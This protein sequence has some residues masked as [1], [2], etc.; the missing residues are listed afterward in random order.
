MHKYPPPEPFLNSE[1]QFCILG[2]INCLKYIWL[3]FPRLFMIILW[4]F[5]QFLCTKCFQFYHIWIGSLVYHILNVFLLH[6]DHVLGLIGSWVS[7]KQSLTF[8]LAIL[9]HSYL[10][11]ALHFETIHCIILKGIWWPIFSWYQHISLKSWWY[12]CFLHQ[13]FDYNQLSKT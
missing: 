9:N 13:S 4:F 1:H 5:W 6:F 11:L 2:M 8:I 7:L 12:I 3:I 10:T